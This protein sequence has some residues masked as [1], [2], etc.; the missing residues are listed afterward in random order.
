MRLGWRSNGTDGMLRT[1][2]IHASTGALTQTALTVAGL[3]VD[4]STSL[5][6]D[7]RGRMLSLVDTVNQLQ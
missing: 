4:G 1:Y 3:G 7:G 5:A 2:S 6:I